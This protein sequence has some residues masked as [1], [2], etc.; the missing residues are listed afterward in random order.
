VKPRT[1]VLLAGLFVVVTGL[2]ILLVPKTVQTGNPVQG[3]MDGSETGSFSCGSALQYGFGNRPWEEADPGTY[4]GGTTF[5]T[6]S[7]VCP[8][9][10]RSNLNAGLLWLLAGVGILVGRWLYLRRHRPPRT[11]DAGAAADGGRRGP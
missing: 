2:L 8:P 7:Q 9:R 1:L 10:L 5:T 3:Q 6:V 11:A 4:A